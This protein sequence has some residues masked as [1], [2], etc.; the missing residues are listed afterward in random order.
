MIGV[1]DYGAGNLHSLARGI[2]HVGGEALVSSDPDELAEQDAIV[3]PGVG[4]A[5]QLLDRL[6]HLGM[7][8]AILDAVDRG[9]PFFGICIGMQI[10][11]G[12]QEEGGATGLGLLPGRVRHLRPGV[13]APHMG[14]NLTRLRRDSP[15]GPAG[16]E[17]YYYFVH[18]FV[19]DDVE[20]RDVVAT[21]NYGETFPS[22]V[23]RDHVWG[24]Q[25]HPEK[26]ADNGMAL[27]KAFVGMVDARRLV[28]A[29]A[30]EMAVR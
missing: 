8:R 22:V 29:G 20:E 23:I 30:T 4:H 26:S 15:L 16:D 28:P 10:L 2:V 19:A 1:I 13:K 27:L 17:R 5:G 11:F 24:T 6:R 14:W 21:T 3:L 18:S 25:F 12:D 7:D 9:T